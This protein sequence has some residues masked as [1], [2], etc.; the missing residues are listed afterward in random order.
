M[1]AWRKFK[2]ENRLRARNSS[3][4]LCQNN[5]LGLL[6]KAFNLSLN[7]TILQKLRS[8]T[9]SSGRRV[10]FVCSNAHIGVSY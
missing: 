1:I 5:I 9:S 2:S 3:V 10:L 7:A 8:R 4:L 6:E